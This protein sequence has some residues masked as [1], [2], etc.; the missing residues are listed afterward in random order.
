MATPYSDPNLYF[1]LA[2]VQTVNWDLAFKALQYKQ[3]QYDTNK[4]RVDTM[5]QKYLTTDII[6]PEAKQ[7]FVNNIQNLVNEINA[8]GRTDFSD[9][10]ISNRVMAHIGQ[11][12]DAPTVSAIAASKQYKQQEAFLKELLSKKPDLYHKNNHE[13]M[14]REKGPGNTGSFYDWLYDGDATSTYSGTLQYTPYV[15]LDKK[16]NDIVMQMMKLNKDTEIEIPD[17]AGRTKKV[18]ISGLSREELRGIAENMFSPEDLQQLA[19]NQRA[20][21]GWFETPESIQLLKENAQRYYQA[22]IETQDA[23]LAELQ[24][25]LQQADPNSEKYQKK[26]ND[27][28]VYTAGKDNILRTLEDLNTTKSLEQLGNHATRLGA[29]QRTQRMVDKYSPMYKELT[30][31]YGVDEYYK[32]SQEFDLKLRKEERE[33]R[34]EQ[35]ELEEQAAKVAGSMGVIPVTTGLPDVL[36][37]ESEI[38]KGLEAQRT[39]IQGNSSAYLQNLEDIRTNPSDFTSQQVA[40][41]S[42]IDIL[43]LFNLKA[44]ATKLGLNVD[45][46][47]P[48][49]EVAKEIDPNGQVLYGVVTSSGGLQLTTGVNRKDENIILDFITSVDKFN[50]GYKEMSELEKQARAEVYNE[51]QTPLLQE[52][53]SGQYQFFTEN[54]GTLD[55]K[56]ELIKEKIL[57]ADGNP[58]AGAKLSDSKWAKDVERTFATGNIMR[59]V[60]G[61]DALTYGLYD[62]ELTTIASSFGESINDITEIQEVWAGGQSGATTTIRRVNPNSKTGQYLLNVGSKYQDRTWIGAVFGSPKTSLAGDGRFSSLFYGNKDYRDTEVYK[63]GIEKQYGNLETSREIFITSDNPLMKDGS[64]RSLLESKGVRMEGGDD[65]QVY[66]RKINDNEIEVFQTQKKGSGADETPERKSFG[67]INIHQIS[68]AAPQVLERLNMDVKQAQY[69]F[70]RVGN[71]VQK[72]TADVNFWNDEVSPQ[73]VWKI[74]SRLGSPEDEYKIKSQTAVRAMLRPEIDDKLYTAISSIV[75]MGI[76]SELVTR[77]PQVLE[78]SDKFQIQARLQP[79]NIGGYYT[80]VSLVDKATN[81]T[82]YQTELPTEQNLDKV[83][84]KI[85]HVPQVLFYD[86]VTSIIKDN[87]EQA[88]DPVN[89]GNNKDFTTPAYKKV[90][91]LQ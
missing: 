63:K 90:I 72:T 37:M 86:I 22:R 87:F 7:R 33:S 76:D 44:E 69:T 12:L 67:V 6:K 58:V 49:S 81:S 73:T 26:Q 48:L 55:L 47:K 24:L 42:M 38:S 45:F 27:I 11:A 8:T 14:Y 88:L 25:E 32:W 70:D 34:K 74:T 36:G 51:D 85:D 65:T 43:Y 28:N 13:N 15:D 1:R 83:K 31:G 17:G 40:E 20:A 68:S 57:D 2:P 29:E 80:E 75:T 61:R 82:V 3:G 56:Q 23:K 5:L 10:N 60:D 18:K 21:Y 78:N 64:F 71:A 50:V 53:S 79:N 54:G 19:I 84:F 35:R 52:V 62:T 91:K 9:S 4:L 46:S 30:V 66:L 39:V 41:A 89:I 59:R 77:L 16:E